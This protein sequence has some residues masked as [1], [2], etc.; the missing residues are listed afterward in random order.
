MAIHDLFARAMAQIKRN[1]SQSKPHRR[2]SSIR[3]VVVVRD[4]IN[5]GMSVHLLA[6]KMLRLVFDALKRRV[7][8]LPLRVDPH[9]ID[10][11][12]IS[13]PPPASHQ[14]AGLS[15]PVLIGEDY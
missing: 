7:L 1:R 13:S 8:Y 2:L 11:F 6:T 15:A 5:S 9:F 12:D 4:H 3:D 10:P 14:R